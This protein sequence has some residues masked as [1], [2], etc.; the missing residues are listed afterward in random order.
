MVQCGKLNGFMKTTNQEWNFFRKHNRV[1][2]RA[3]LVA[4]FLFCMASSRAQMLPPPDPF[5]Q[6]DSWSFNDTNWLSNLGYP[7]VSFANLNNPPG[8]DG[9]ALQ[10][11]STNAA[12]LQYNI[13]ESDG[14]TNLT[15]NEGAI[16]LWVLPDWNSG[17]GPGDWGRL[18]DVG[19][20]GTNNPSSW[21]SLYLTPDGSTV[22]FSSETNGVFTN[23]RS[24]LAWNGRLTNFNGAQVYNFYSSGEEVLRE[25]D[26]DPPTNVLSD[27][28]QIVED[29]LVSGSP[30]ASYVWVWQEKSK[31]RA[32][33]DWLLGSTH[34]GWKF[35]TNYVSLTVAQANALPSPQLQTNAFFDF[36]SPTFT[37]DLA[38]EEGLGNLYA[39]YN[40]N[41]IIADAIPALSFPVGANPVPGFNPLGRNFDMQQLYENSWP[42]GRPPQRAGATALGEW[43]HSDFHQV[44]YTF[45]Y[46]L[47]DKLAT[48]GNLK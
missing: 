17:T 42:L 19:A 7:P 20:Y 21:W 14:T 40:H 37:D 2:A 44:A 1:L 6:L 10:V 22:C 5:F 47:F 32:A 26:V 33:N 12:W 18:I 43:W 34:G 36:S 9:N 38:L 29:A 4:G 46:Q 35:N 16:E 48:T 31:G 30:V 23:Y 8:F 24:T 45:T 41:R 15:F 28:A 39:Y 27:V 25:W 3:I 11:D 13:V